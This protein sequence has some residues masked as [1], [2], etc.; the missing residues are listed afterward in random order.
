MLKVNDYKTRIVTGK[1]RLSYL[2]LFTPR[3]VYQGQRLKYRLCLLI[4]KEDKETIDIIN[5]AI[6]GAVKIGRSLWGDE[7]PSEIKLPLRDG[8]KEKPENEEF[9]GHYFLNS[10]SNLKPGIVD[11]GLVEIKNPDEIYPGCYGRASLS[12]Y[13]FSQEGVHGVACRLQNLQKLEDG[14]P[15][16]L[17]P[18]PEEDFKSS[19]IDFLG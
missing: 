17:Q 13:P 2:N 3:A 18:K 4:D 19:D 15:L 12:F 11:K 6:E 8:D 5:K 9:K 7:T 10:S 1:C 14:E 16:Y